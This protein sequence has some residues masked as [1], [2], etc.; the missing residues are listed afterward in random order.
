MR[1][2]QADAN[3]IEWDA[4]ESEA[5]G[6]LKSLDMAAIMN[7]PRVASGAPCDILADDRLMD[8]IAMARR[9]HERLMRMPANA[10]FVLMVAYAG[11]LDSLMYPKFARL[12]GVVMLTNAARRAYRNATA[13]QRARGRPFVRWL[14]RETNEN[15]DLR[16]AVAEEAD[17][18]LSNAVAHWKAA[19][20]WQTTR[21]ESTTR[22]SS[23]LNS[24]GV[25]AEPSIDGSKRA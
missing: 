12:S 25:T 9:I 1:L 18:M 4:N 7:A 10:R 15:R 17:T 22:R 23:W 2:S 6:G 5:L 3:R 13:K 11:K 21:E 24:S 20:D 19:R 14:S 8:Q 16:E